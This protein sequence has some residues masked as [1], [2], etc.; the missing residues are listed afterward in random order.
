EEGSATLFRLIGMTAVLGLCL[1]LACFRSISAT[2][3]IVFCGGISAVLTL[4]M[5]WWF[6]STVDAIAMSMPALVYVLGLSGATHLINYYYDAV[7]QGGLNGAPERSVMIG[8]KPNLMCNITTAIG[9]F[10]LVTSELIPIQKFGIFAG[11]G[12]LTA[13]LIE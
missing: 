6:G 3:M 5:M 9:L 11:L 7:D 10:S 8:W 2:I 4:A 13:T 12:V 1:S